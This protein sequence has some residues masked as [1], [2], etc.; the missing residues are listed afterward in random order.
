MRKIWNPEHP[1]ITIQSQKLLPVIGMQTVNFDSLGVKHLV[2]E[3]QFR[4]HARKL[5]REWERREEESIYENFQPFAM[6]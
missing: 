4:K 1:P 2:N 3:S 6:P 5:Q